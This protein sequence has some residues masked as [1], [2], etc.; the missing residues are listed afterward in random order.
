MFVSCLLCVD[1]K[2]H[3]NDVTLQREQTLKER[4]QCERKKERE[5][6]LIDRYYLL[7]ALRCGIPSN[8]ERGKNRERERE[9]ERGGHKE[10]I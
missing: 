2:I 8:G 10:I 3:S 4:R 9:E 7:S 6:R 1:N 5:R